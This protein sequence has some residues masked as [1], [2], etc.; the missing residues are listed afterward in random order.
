[1]KAEWWLFFGLGA[2][3]GYRMKVIATKDINSKM[4]AVDGG[5]MIGAVTFFLH[6]LITGKHTSGELK[7][8]DGIPIVV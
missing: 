3:A 4:S 6:Y 1:M 5:L 8:I 7:R 2:F